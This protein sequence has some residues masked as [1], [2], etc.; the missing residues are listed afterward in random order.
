[1]KKI[2][3]LLLALFAA[4]CS[5]SYI[6]LDVKQDPNYI[7]YFAGNPGRNHFT[8]AVLKDT[9]AFAW[10]NEMYGSFGFNAVVGYDS[11]VF[12]NDL[13]GKIF[14][15]NIYSGKRAGQVKYRGTVSVSPLIH[16]TNII[17]TVSDYNGPGTTIYSYDFTRGSER[18]K[19]S[20]T[21]K[22][23]NEGLVIGDRFFFVT[24][25]GIVLLLDQTGS[26]LYSEETELYTHSY[27]V[28][29]TDFVYWGTD[30]GSIVRY[31]H[32][33]Q[34]EN[35]RLKIS[36][37]PLG[38]GAVYDG[39]Y[40]ILDNQGTLFAVSLKDF[41]LNWKL[42]VGK[43]SAAAPV[44][45]GKAL[46]ITAQ[47]GTLFRINPAGVA[48]LESK[49]LPGYFNTAPLV[50]ANAL[51][52]AA[53]SGNLLVVDKESLDIRQ[54]IQF[55]ARMKLIPVLFKGYIFTGMDS[56]ILQAYKVNTGQ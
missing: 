18:F 43:K 46:W 55:D 32:T 41:K 10:Q 6:K 49:Q 9:L 14:A 21:G 17:F 4:G 11:V 53:H 29:N 27:P 34:S 45:D 23:L 16:K 3:I 44:H 40:Y 2:F 31:N 24:E 50:L 35:G 13:S 54:E 38:N 22:I 28:M 36:D 48:V 51:I 47:D 15:Y 5:G 19:H 7:P 30:R 37:F 25:N 52:F 56:G 12:I 1:M 26:V 8:D 42:Y 33:T 39:N 20:F